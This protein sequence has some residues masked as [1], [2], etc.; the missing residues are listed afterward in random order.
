MEPSAD[1]VVG[2]GWGDESKGAT[3]DALAAANRPNRVVRFNGGQQA[4]HNVIANGVHHTFSSFGAGT[5]AGAETWISRFCTVSPMNLQREK[6]ALQELGYYEDI[7]VDG[8]CLVTT[9]LH[10]TAN[11]TRESV[12]NH[13]TTGTGFGETVYY[14]LTHGDDALRVKHLSS[15]SEMLPRLIKLRDFYAEKGLIDPDKYST[16]VLDYVHTSNYQKARAKF[17][18]VTSDDL[19]EA[20]QSGYTVFEG[21]QGFVLDE[22]F[23]FSPHTTWSTTTPANARKLL[24]EAGV[25]NVRTIGCLRT[26]ATRHGNGPLPHEGK[27]PFRPEEPHNADDNTQGLFRVAPHDPEIIEWAIDTTGVDVLSI[28]HLDVFDKMYT[29]HGMVDLQELP[30]RVIMKSYGPEREDRKILDRV[31]QYC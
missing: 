5:F 24:R 17:T 15:R 21:A 3:V 6:A 9:D 16:K 13:G 20:L 19:T 10:I 27:L 11:L 1:I 14:G 26:Y 4:A 2:L 30:R 23:G 8:D 12:N 28:S 25:E 31:E 18:T 22:N 29:S 7:Y